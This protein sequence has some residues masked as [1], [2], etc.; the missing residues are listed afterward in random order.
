MRSLA[1]CLLLLLPVAAHSGPASDLAQQLRHSTLDVEEC[2]RVRDLRFTRDELKLYFTDGLLIFSKPVGGTRVSAVF[3]ADVE[4][5]DGEI[6]LMPP[7]SSER[8]S[9]AAF[10]KSPNL[11]EHFKQA[12]MVFSDDA[13]TELLEMV[14]ASGARK[15]PEM[16]N[17]LAE[18]WSPVV[19]SF[20]ASFE[21]RLVQDLLSTRRKS[22]GFFF[23]AFGG[24]PL[25][26]FDTVYD[27][28]ASHHISVGQVTYRDDRRFFDIWTNFA[29]QSFRKG[30]KAPAKQDLKIEGFQIQATIEPDLSMKA[31]SRLKIQPLFADRTIALELSQ[32][33]KIT[34][35]KVNGMPADVFSPESLR[36]NLLRG[37]DSNLLLISTD[38]EFN[39]GETV[40]VEVQHEGTVIL[41]AGDGVYF[42]G[43]RG[44]WYPNRSQQFAP[45]DVTFRF[46]KHL[47]LVATGDL[48]DEQ[49]EGEWKISHRKTSTPA[50]I[51]GFNL[52]NY[53]RTKITRGGVTVEVCA[54]KKLEAALQPKPRP[55]E[56][57]P[58]SQFPRPPRRGQIPEMVMV[59]QSI[60]NP[61]ARLQQLA[62][63]FVATFEEM[64]ARF[65]KPSLR[66]LTV[67]PIPGRFGQGFSG[68]VYLSTLVYLDPSERPVRVNST[69]QVFFSE[70]LH[71]HEIAH[72]WWGNGV[73]SEDYQA[74]WLME[75]LANYSALWTLERKKGIKALDSM[76]ERYKDDLLMKDADGRTLES[77]GSLTLGHRIFSSHSPTAWPVITY[78]KGAWV[79]HML[80]R[81]MGDERFAKMLAQFY[82]RYL[83]QGVST[84]QFQKVAAEFMPPGSADPKLDN[85][86]D[87]WVNGTG[88]PSLKLNWTVSG[89]APKL[90]L[91][92]TVTQ[93]DVDE[94]FGAWVPVEIQVARAKPIVKWI[95]TSSEPVQF[96]VALTTAPLK[97]TLDPGNATL[98]RK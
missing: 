62:A 10:A 50:R 32:R 22:V 11:D 94:D 52:G 91:T 20:L 69:D 77:A 80:R 79:L 76:L 68:L 70:L 95:Q 67:S 3:S 72:Q 55:L 47:D 19:N 61:A 6:L 16:G 84:E 13:A 25:G 21:V 8:R 5:G 81:R 44:V 74:D 90:K 30:Q 46:P 2:Y 87:Q 51:F 75:A 82:Q 54:N 73:T 38:R 56:L 97:V 48:V 33:M 65:G 27:P 29:G 15:N 71:A 23:S 39:A 89:K 60:P 17:V 24:T 40:E 57:P 83:F 43:A 26:N 7:T 58:T 63:D 59:P 86:F 34:A 53:E 88:I 28:R 42:V 14:K 4:G 41:Q 31:I 92:G 9:L 45:Y 93:S 12:V 37:T 18:K 1:P 64:S 96:D 35:V 85:F 66:T 78:E 49:V 36:A 98:A